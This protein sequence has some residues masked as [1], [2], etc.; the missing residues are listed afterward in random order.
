MILLNTGLY[1]TTIL[2]LTKQ[3]HLRIRRRILPACTVTSYEIVNI[4]DS[5]LVTSSCR[6][7][8]S[9]V[10][11]HLQRFHDLQSIRRT[12][13]YG[14]RRIR[15]HWRTKAKAATKTSIIQLMAFQGLEST[16]LSIRQ[17]TTISATCRLFGSS[18]AVYLIGPWRRWKEC[19][20]SEAHH[21][22]APFVIS[23]T[24]FRFSAPTIRFLL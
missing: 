17:S 5:A 24:P 8:H 3:R 7:G 1:T 12:N 10:Y 22:S 13:E 19:I 2:S 6:N 20:P 9:P 14:T 23:H 4:V 21:S 11:L 18:L 16:L 15:Y